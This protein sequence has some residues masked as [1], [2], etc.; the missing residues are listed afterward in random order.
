MEHKGLFNSDNFMPHGHCYL[1]KPEILWLNVIS[2]FIIV[3]AY[4]SIPILLTYLVYKTEAKLKFN[5]L[6]LLFSIFILACGTTHLMEI[7]NV[8]NSEYFLAGIIKAI[9][10]IASILTAIALIPV[11]P[12]IIELLKESDAKNS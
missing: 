2:D 1:W 3:C 12:Q 9:T 11:I 6:F 7:I 10:A 5:W 8:W 4:F